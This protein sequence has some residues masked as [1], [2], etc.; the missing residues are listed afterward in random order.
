MRGSSANDNG[1]AQPYHIGPHSG[2]PGPP[3]QRNFFVP[4]FLRCSASDDFETMT[5]TEVF[6]SVFRPLVAL[7]MTGD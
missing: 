5:C 1:P 2:S 6:V 7:D 4:P 3:A